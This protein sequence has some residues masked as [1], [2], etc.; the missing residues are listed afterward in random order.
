MTLD[1]YKNGQQK[2]KHEI[3]V[4]ENTLVR[5]KKEL[6]LIEDLIHKLEEL[7]ALKP[8]WLNKR[9][10]IRNACEKTNDMFTTNDIKKILMQSNDERI[11]NIPVGYISGQLC[12]LVQEKKISLV[13]K[14]ARKGSPNNYKLN[15]E[16]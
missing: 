2:L 13:G 10:V 5:Y 1:Q 7:E 16:K 9:K 6:H 3:S 14:E 11:R 8:Q 15:K 12:K 4:L